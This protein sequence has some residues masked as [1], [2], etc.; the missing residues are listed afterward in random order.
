MSNVLNPRCHLEEN[1]LFAAIFRVAAPQEATG[2]N[3][4]HDVADE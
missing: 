4:E 2:A 3:S 1:K